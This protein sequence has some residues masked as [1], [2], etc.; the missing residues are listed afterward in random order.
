MREEIR[1]EVKAEF[2]GDGGEVP[3]EVA[4]LFQ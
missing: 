2:E 1:A 4:S 3:A